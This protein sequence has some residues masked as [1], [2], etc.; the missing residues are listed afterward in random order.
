MRAINDG[1][2]VIF[3]NGVT[4]RNKYFFASHN[5]A[6]QSYGMTNA[7]PVCLVN[8]MS[9]DGRIFL[10]DIVLDLIAQVAHDKNKFLDASFIE[11]IDDDTKHSFACKRDQSLG[12]SVSV[13]SQFGSGSSY[14][15]D[16]LHSCFFEFYQP[17]K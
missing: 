13:R 1:M 2:H 9:S 4:Q 16:C 17:V 11:L 10:S 15:N 8:K 6:C 12:L 3:A 14:W 5:A 7:L